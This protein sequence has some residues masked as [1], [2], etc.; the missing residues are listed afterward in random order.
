MTTGKA[1]DLGLSHFSED[2]APP[3]FQVPWNAR[4]GPKDMGTLALFLVANWFVNGELQRF[5]V[6]LL[7]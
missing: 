5:M 1:D 4:G 7:C 3:P 2:M 6:L